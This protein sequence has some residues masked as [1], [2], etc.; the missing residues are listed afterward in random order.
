M[1][2]ERC[3]EEGHTRRTQGH[4]SNVNWPGQT[5]A[6]FFQTRFWPGWPGHLTRFW[7]GWPGQMTRFWPDYLN[8]VL[9]WLFDHVLTADLTNLTWRFCYFRYLNNLPRPAH[10]QKNYTSYYSLT[11]Q[12]FVDFFRYNWTVEWWIKGGPDNSIIVAWI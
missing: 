6:E 8:K 5:W 4:A 9:T 2:C 10:S 11:Y 3:G 1:K 7:Q 12:P